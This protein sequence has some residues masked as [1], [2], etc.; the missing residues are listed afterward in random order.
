MEEDLLRKKR[1]VRASYF[2]GKNQHIF[3][4]VHLGLKSKEVSQIPHHPC[5]RFPFLS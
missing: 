1:A 2:G 3:I 4:V 5:Q